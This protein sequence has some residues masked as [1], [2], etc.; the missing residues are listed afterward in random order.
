VWVHL[1]PESIADVEGAYRWRDDAVARA[2]DGMDPGGR[3]AVRAFLGSLVAELTP[4]GAGADDGRAD[5][6]S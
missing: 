1:S 6:A 2:L 4:D 3:A 5:D